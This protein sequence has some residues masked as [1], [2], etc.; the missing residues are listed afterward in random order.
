M[1]SMIKRIW[2]IRRRISFWRNPVGASRKLGVKVGADCRFLGVSPSTFGSEPY[3]ISIGDHVTVTG[4]VRFV[5]HDGGVWVLRDEHPE[6]DVIS[7]ISI[8]N[9]VFIGLRVVILPGVTIGNNVVVAA[10]SVVTKSFGDDVVI[11][12]VPARVLRTLDDYRAAAVGHAVNTKGLTPQQ[13]RDFL[14]KH[15]N[16]PTP[17]IMHK[18]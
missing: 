13:K 1:L 3:L 5:T 12:G 15:V 2:L 7:P 14:L 16:L 10:G 4:D 9:N 8:G 6:I 18:E 17:S 11:G